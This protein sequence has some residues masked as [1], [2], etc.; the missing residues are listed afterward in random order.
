MAV[1][2]I[3]LLHPGVFDRDEDAARRIAIAAGHL[4]IAV[5][6]F[7]KSEDIAPFEPDF[8]IA[9]SG[10][11]AKLTRFPTYGLIDSPPSF[12]EQAPRLVRNVC[13]YDASLTSSPQVRQWI[14]DIYFGA[15]KR[16]APIAFF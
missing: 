16:N 3:A 11:D 15:H 14:A 13:T 12:Y 5:E 7:E 4:G 2:K 9:L 1:K 8:V 6:V 10:Q